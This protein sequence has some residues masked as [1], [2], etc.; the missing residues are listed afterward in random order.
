MSVFVC[1]Q[2]VSADPN[3]ALALA[4]ESK[5]V[6]EKDEEHLYPFSESQAIKLGRARPPTGKPPVIYPPAKRVHCHLENICHSLLGWL[7]SLNMVTFLIF[8][9]V[10]S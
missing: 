9:F 5:I 4:S 10:R 3:I 2:G 7:L 1:P 8:V 6:K